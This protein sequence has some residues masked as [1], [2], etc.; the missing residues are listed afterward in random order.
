MTKKPARP[1][2]HH[3]DNE[4]L[5][6][7][8]GGLRP[9]SKVHFVEPGHHI[10]GEGGRLT[11][12]HTDSGKVVKDLGILPKAP[13]EEERKPGRPMKIATRRKG[14]SAPISPAPITPTPVTPAPITDGWIVYSGWTNESGNPISYF[15][16][17]WTV[18]PNPAVN[19]N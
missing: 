6:L 8:P 10:S 15:G 18:P 5:V 2:T 16:T 1:D 13:L 19:A 7:T 12:V 17:R 11:I 9:K 14:P 4:E 3:H